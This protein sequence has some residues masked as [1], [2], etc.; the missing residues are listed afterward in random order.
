MS[1]IVGVR[2]PIAKLIIS[3]DGL[4]HMRIAQARQ[5]D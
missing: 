1:P 2:M 3:K 5:V 4:V